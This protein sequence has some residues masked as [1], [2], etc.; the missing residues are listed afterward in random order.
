MSPRLLLLVALAGCLVV[1]AAT[2]FGLARSDGDEVADLTELADTD[3]EV[4]EFLEPW[5]QALGDQERAP[6]KIVVVG[7]SISEGADAAVPIHEIRFVRLLQNMLREQQDV[8]G[9]NGY[10][11][12]F[13]GDIFSADDAVRT[14][15][16]AQ[17][18]TYDRWGLGAAHSSCRR[19]P[20]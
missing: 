1:G 12:A 16:P 8:V 2:A 13:Y 5:F 6:A 4:R 17:E 14:G 11:P 18:F 7:D 15:T 20:R 9:G 10:F 3:A 19:A